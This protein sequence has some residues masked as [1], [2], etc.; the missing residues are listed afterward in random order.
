MPID[1]G[2]LYLRAVTDRA[3]IIDEMLRHPF[4]TGFETSTD[5]KLGWVR[6]PATVG[7]L[8]VP[9]GV[10]VRV[11]SML[12]ARIARGPDWENLQAEQFYSRGHEPLDGYALADQ[13]VL[14]QDELAK[15]Q[16]AL[17]EP[18]TAEVIV[19]PP[20]DEGESSATFP[21]SQCEK[22]CG[23]LAGLQAHMRA[24]HPEAG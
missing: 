23:S 8:A 5:G 2:Y 20:T 10:A 3:V 16:T 18:T 7:R 22:V 15:A 11:P 14:L 12:G 17:A 24:K 4:C 6:L 9:K 13:V 21:C 19:P 1:S